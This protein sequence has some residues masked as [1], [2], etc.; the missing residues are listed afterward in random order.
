MNQQPLLSI[1]IPAYNEVANLRQGVLHRLASYLATRP[2]THEVLISDDGST[3]ETPR[4][5]EAFSRD[6]PSFRFLRKRHRGKAQAVISGLLAARGRYLMFMD[7][8]L[9]TSLQHI[10]DLLDA[11]QQGADVVIASRAAKGA[12]RLGTPLSRRLLARAFN[13][14]IQ[15]LLLPGLRDTQC[16]FKGFR[17]E[18]A[19][20]LIRS[21]VVF[22]RAPLALGPRVTAFDVELLVVARERGYDVR[23]IPVTW[24]HVKSPRVSILREPLLMLGEI[25]SIWWAR[26]RGR[27]RPAADKGGP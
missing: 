26:R 18:V 9:A 11:L 21:L 1:V 3:D 5:V 14:F 24:Q 16:G 10:D 6:H 17:R 4:L 27:Y 13:L 20:E 2:Y 25:L 19:E 12:S 7:M 23:E 15:A 8:D 22:K